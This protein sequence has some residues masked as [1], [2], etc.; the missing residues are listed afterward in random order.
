LLDARAANARPSGRHGA[1]ASLSLSAE[2]YIA[3]IL[4]RFAHAYP[5][6][7]IDL[8]LDDAFVDVVS[9]GDGTTLRI[10][11]VIERDMIA[12]RLGPE[13]RQIAVTAPVYVERN[14]AP[15]HPRELVDHPASDGDGRGGPD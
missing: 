6:I 4:G 15:A 3:P 7:V 10:R 8:T 11:E 13:L 2:R 5:D 12:V 9:G 1:R 14:G